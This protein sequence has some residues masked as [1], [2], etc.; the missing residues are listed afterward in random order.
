MVGKSIRRGLFMRHPLTKWV[1]RII[2]AA[3]LFFCNAPPLN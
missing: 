2:I 1:A 3:L